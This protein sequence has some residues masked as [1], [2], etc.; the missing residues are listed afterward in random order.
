MEQ[1]IYSQPTDM[2]GLAEALGQ[3]TEKTVLLGGGTDLL[4]MIQ[5][6]HPP[7]D[8]YISLGKIPDLGKIEEQ[9]GF[10]KIGAMATHHQIA[11]NPLVEKYFPALSMACSHVGSQQI[12]NKGTIGGSLANASP[13]GD[14]MPCVFLFKGEIEIYNKNQ[15]YR[16]IS[17]EEFLI[18]N[19]RTALSLG[20][21]VSALWLPIREERKSCF[22]KLGARTDVTIAQISL[23]LSWEKKENAIEAVRA[24]LG[25]VDVRPLYLPEAEELLSGE[26]SREK[27]D[28]LAESLRA[29]IQG[30]RERRK[31]Q[32]KLRITEAERL[33]KER[34]VKGIVYDA[35]E[36]MEEP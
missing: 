9:D 15:E 11:G 8:R 14:M 18:G 26:I 3:A 25:A 2:D 21:A 7:I 12:R 32:P 35:A 29:R 33:Y 22:V 5:K 30:I 27:K 23:A 28:A 24:Y 13:A 19:Q 10:L 17:G 36:Y 31:R 1:V 4:I 34:A 16:R 20:E 6:K